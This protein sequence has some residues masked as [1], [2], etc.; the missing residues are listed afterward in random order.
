MDMQALLEKYGMK[1]H[2]E[3]GR[4][5]ERHYPYS[6]E[7]RAASGSTYFY[8][9]P[10]ERTLFHVIDCD[11]YWCH[12][13]G[14]ALEVWTVSPDGTLT[15]RKFGTEPDAEPMLYFPKG[16]IFASRNPDAD[17]EGAFFTCITVP[18]FDYRGFRLVEKDEVLKI[19]PKAAAFWNECE[20]R[21]S[22][23]V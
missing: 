15:V 16:A 7:G 23:S 19:C 10:G 12:H 3:N 17:G 5:A 11:E 21:A 18:R 14:S 2:E 4:Y 22:E 1:P 9:A 13:A 8:T 20:K 6:G